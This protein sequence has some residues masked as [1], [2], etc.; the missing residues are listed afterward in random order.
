MT[1]MNDRPQGGSVLLNGRIELMQ[2][3][4]LF[5]DDWKGVNEALDEVDENGNGITVPATY[6]VEFIDTK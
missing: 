5:E 2:N 3:R 1:V 4:R 6:Y